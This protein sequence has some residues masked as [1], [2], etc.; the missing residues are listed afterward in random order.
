MPLD[1]TSPDP[2]AR[3][4]YNDDPDAPPSDLLPRADLTATTIL[5]GAHAERNT[6]G[7]LFATQIASAIATKNPDEK[8]LVVVGLGLE[9]ATVGRE[10]FMDLLGLVLGVI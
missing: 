8:R 3:V 4:S 6:V 9:K 1:T 10:A 2:T 5:G 7:Q